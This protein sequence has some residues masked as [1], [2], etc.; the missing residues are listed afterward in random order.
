MRTIKWKCGSGAC[1]IVGMLGDLDL[2]AEAETEAGKSIPRSSLHFFRRLS[3]PLPLVLVLVIYFFLFSCSLPSRPTSRNGLGHASP[4]RA[5]AASC[6][7]V[8]FVGLRVRGTES[9]WGEVLVLDY[10]VGRSGAGGEY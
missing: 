6:S 9:T 4:R 2:D 5:R 10:G 1:T 7:Y 3:P 8:H